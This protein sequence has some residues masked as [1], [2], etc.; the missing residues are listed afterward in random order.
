MSCTHKFA[1][2]EHPEYVQCIEC[3]TYKSTIA[4]PP[5]SLYTEDYWS[6]AHSTPE[7]QIYN[8]DVHLERGV[9]KNN[10]LLSRIRCS[11]RN[12]ALDIG[13]F[14]GIFLKRLAEYQ[15]KEVVGLDAIEIPKRLLQTHGINARILK[16]Y[17]PGGGILNRYFHY[18]NTIPNNHYDLVTALDVLEHSDAP[19]AFLKECFQVCGPNGQLLLML[20]LV[21]NNW[22]EPRMLAPAEHVYLHDIGN[23]KLL[24]EEA[25]FSNVEFSE[26]A[27][28]HDV[29]SARKL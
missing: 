19:E 22:V 26:W 3:G 27:A 7:A 6:G 25:G 5:E 18:G 9:T 8:V 24:L 14:P 17:F 20:P 2:C 13:C 12:A 10:Y 16:G 28:G 4:H 1:R 23:I 21:K 11:K 29:I 15:F